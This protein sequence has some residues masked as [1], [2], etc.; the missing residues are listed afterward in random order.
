MILDMDG[1][2][3][4]ADQ[5][6]GDLPHLFSEIS[7]RG[8]RIVL[9]TNNATL[10]IEQFLDKLQ[11]FGVE[12][13]SWQVV[14][15]SQ[16]AAHY[17]SQ[18]YPRGGPVFIIG[19]EGLCQELSKCGYYQADKDVLAVVVGMDHHLT[20][21]K[22]KVAALLI[23]TGAPFIGTNPDRT[24]PTPYGLVPGSGAILAALETA[25]SVQPTIMGKPSPE[26]YLLALERLRA[27]PSETLVVGDR[28]ETDIAG[29]QAI[30]C[31]TALV[32]SGV[33]SEEEARHY[34]PSPDFIAPDLTSLLEIL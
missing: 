9:A 17:L 12:L 5:P 22:L 20:Y 13:A 27:S 34:A 2:L 7:K 28:L 32:L 15:S 10:T 4:R 24:Y 1:V 18:R 16:T 3:W 29:A 23:Q 31:R 25:T 8:Y 11:G 26:L 30:G 6:I 33:S 14:N 19:E 21:E